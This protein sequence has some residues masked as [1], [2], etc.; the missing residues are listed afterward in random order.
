MARAAAFQ[1]RAV[2][3]SQASFPVRYSQ[4]DD[5]GVV[6]AKHNVEGKPAKDRPPEIATEDWKS[7]RREAKQINHPS[8]S[9]GVHP[10]SSAAR[11]V[12][13]LLQPPR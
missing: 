4:D 3:L 1:V 11:N 6:C 2:P 5:A 8:N 12:S 13:P 10:R 9:I 7:I